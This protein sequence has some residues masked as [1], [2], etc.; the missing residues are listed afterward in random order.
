MSVGYVH[1][2]RCENGDNSIGLVER[3]E[4][5]GHLACVKAALERGADV[6][7]VDSQGDTALIIA[8]AIGCAECIDVLAN[9]GADVNAKRRNFQS[10]L[11]MASELGHH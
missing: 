1:C 11:I 8:S 3:V 7:Q 5:P 4:V 9:A 6:N 10:S 2:T